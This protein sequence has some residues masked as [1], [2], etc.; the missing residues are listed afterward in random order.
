MKFISTL[1]FAASL[2][3]ASPKPSV[4]HGALYFLDSDPQG[5]SV[6]SF[7]IDENGIPRNPQRT[8]TSGS[9]LIG[10]NVNGTVKMDPLFSQ[11]S[12]IVNGNL[13]FT[14][15]AGSNTLAAFHIPKHDPV[16]P[17]L[18]GKPAD[19]VGTTP[20]TVAYSRKNNIACVANTGVNPG[21]QCFTVSR[22]HGLKPVGSLKP[23]PVQAQTNPITGPPNTV[24]D[25]LFNPSET[26]LFVTIKGD[27]LSDGYVYAYKVNDGTVS[28][29]VVVSRPINLPVAFG[30]SFYSDDAAVIVT[31][32]YGAAFVSITEGLNVVT[33]YNITVP[34]QVATCWSVAS[35]DSSSVYLLDAGVANIT[36]LNT[37]TMAI[38]NTLS[39]YEMGMGNFDGIIAGSKL[40]V[41]QAAPSIATFD[42]EDPSCGLEV[43]DLSG[44]GERASWIGMAAYS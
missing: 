21:V 3:H 39:G 30:M 17:I 8:S 18:L 23:L 26:A 29:E 32:A 12:I 5:A 31:P 4:S 22:R 2:A 34:G 41:L 1:A 27:G 19:T 28:E 24:S 37:E 35:E 13:L 38:E 9:G 44:L 42:L 43:T 36:S 6:V 33:E 7:S 11:G 16:H 14:V 40:Y 20:S 25:I 10:M 15:N